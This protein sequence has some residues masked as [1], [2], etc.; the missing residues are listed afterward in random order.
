MKT[1]RTIAG[2]LIL[3]TLSILN[4]QPSTAF[5][6]GTT[7]FTY[8]GQLRDGGTNANGT[9]TMIFKL[10]DAA[11]GGNQIGGGITNSPAL[12]NGLFTVNLDFGNVFNGSARWLDITVQSGSDIETLTPRVQVLPAPYAIYAGSA[13]SLSGGA[14]N[15]SVGNCQSYSNVMLFT[16]NGSVVF[17]M[18]TNGAMINGDLNA[19]GNIAGG[20]IIAEN[21]SAGVTITTYGGIH[22][23]DKCDITITGNG[24][25]DLS[26]NGGIVANGGFIVSD[27]N[28][29]WVASIDSSGNINASGN[30]SATNFIV[31]DTNGN[32]VASI[33]SS[34][35]IKAN[36]NI[37]AAN[38]LP[39]GVPNGMQEFSTPGTYSFTVPTNITR[40]LVEL[41]GGGG[42]GGLGLYFS[43]GGGG[44]SRSIIIVT[45]GTTINVIVG[46]GGSGGI[47]STSSDPYDLSPYNGGDG[48]N[49]SITLTNG[50]VLLSSGG[51]KG[52]TGIYLGVPQPSAPGG[53]GGSP[54][55]NAAIQRAGTSGVTGFDNNSAASGGGSIICPL[56]NYYAIH[57]DYLPGNT[58]Q[59]TPGNG[60]D[61]SG[62]NWGSR[63]A[64]SGQDGYIFIQW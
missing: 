58:L 53:A 59:N 56:Y 11:G 41:W 61:A 22:I 15:A 26:L 64:Y 49:S 3:L 18:S 33:D 44:Y 54:D 12:A 57:D 30:I 39:G 16:D 20:T 35:N 47:T 42:G 23:L 17:G 1:N 25:G 37:S 34:G 29:N 36:G 45:P 28:G 4:L 40:L 50:T 43:G 14:W 48:G 5:A 13:A 52:G 21:Q 63:H 62:E 32:W 60:G 6:Q 31:S 19:N 46:A 55:P 38:F 9:Y 2:W 10:Y 7:A 24:Q 51:G 27:T 8:Q